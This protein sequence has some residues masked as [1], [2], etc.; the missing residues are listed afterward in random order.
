MCPCWIFRAG[1]ARIQGWACPLCWYLSLQPLQAVQVVNGSDESEQP[2][3]LLQSPPFHLLEHSDDLH[4]TKRSFDALPLAL[5]YSVSRMPGRALVD[6]TRPFLV[7][8]RDMRD[9]LH[10]P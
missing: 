3:P 8:L 9:N 7:V 5:T 1:S 4:P 10:P 2:A 6:V